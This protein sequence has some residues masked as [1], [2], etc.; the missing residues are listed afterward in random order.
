MTTSVELAQFGALLGD[1]TRAAILDA[2]IDGRALTAKELAFRARVTPQTAS[3]HLKKLSD[4]NLLSVLSQGRHRY[5][6]LAS[7]LIGQMIE[8][9]GAAAAIHA[10]P[11]HR[12]PGPRDAQLREARMCYDHLAGR[13]AVDLAQALCQRS[14][15]RLEPDGGEITAEGFRFFESL[16]I[17]LQ[18]GRS[19]RRTFCKPC[20]DWSER[21]FHIGGFLGAA[22]AHHCTAQG[23][24]VRDRDSRAV[25]V[26]REGRRAML[27]PVGALRRADRA[28]GLGPRLHDADHRPIAA[29]AGRVVAAELWRIK[30]GRRAA[31]QEKRV[32][33]VELVAEQAG[34]FLRSSPSLPR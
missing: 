18:G 31:V 7:P 21:R 29:V 3:L 13:V 10:P 16:G 4:G 19:A 28:S 6:R 5:F 17:D 30:T 11:R 12:L 20:L 34:E 24:I 32:V 9:V 8:A 33:A 1:S 2:L 22:I 14:L 26:T 15:V 27:E 25:E 23:W